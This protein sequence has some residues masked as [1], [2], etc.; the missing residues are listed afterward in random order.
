MPKKKKSEKKRE[1]QT[2]EFIFA[3]IYR[4]WWVDNVGSEVVYHIHPL[5]F[6]LLL[7]QRGRSAFLLFVVV[8]VVVI[9]ESF[10]ERN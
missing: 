3:D 8:V 4:S 5:S 9:A 7:F 1:E 10:F 2:F 6:Y